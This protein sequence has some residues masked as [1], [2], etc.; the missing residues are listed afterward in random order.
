MTLL[1]LFFSAAPSVSNLQIEGDATEDNTLIGVGTYFGGKEGSSKY[2]WLREKE[3]GYVLSTFF[4]GSFY[5][6]LLHYNH[7]T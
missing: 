6:L 3:N 4:H 1:L 7:S 5:L 2:K